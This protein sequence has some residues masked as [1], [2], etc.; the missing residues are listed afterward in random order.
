MIG[1]TFW[2]STNKNKYSMSFGVTDAMLNV[3]DSHKQ[4]SGKERKL[5]ESRKKMAKKSRKINR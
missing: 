1:S 2:K 4:L 5:R 3:N